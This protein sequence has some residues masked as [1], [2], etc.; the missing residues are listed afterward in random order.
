MSRIG[1]KPIE[2]PSGTKVELKGNTVTVSGPKGQ[3]SYNVD[4]RMSVKVED[5]QV[6]VARSGQDKR[7]RELHGLTRALIA[8]MAHGVTT[9]YSKRLLIY[10]TGYGCNLNGKVLELNLGYMGRSVNKGPQFSIPVPQG[11]E[12]TVETA[13][14]RGETDPAKFVISGADRQA[15]GQF[16]AEIRALRKPEPYKG[17]GVRY[18]NEYVRRKQGKALTSGG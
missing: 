17:K 7:S 1:K 15:V 5:Q 12:V 11:I 3:L 16:A 14:A 6:T 2:L 8:N 4:P 13:A 10:G 9:G 18:E